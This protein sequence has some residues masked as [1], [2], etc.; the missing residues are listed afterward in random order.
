MFDVIFRP[1]EQ[2][3]KFCDKTRTL[4]IMLV[5]YVFFLLY[6]TI[7]FNDIFFRETS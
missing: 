3:V 6:V 5:A 1:S 2:I 7:L 4:F